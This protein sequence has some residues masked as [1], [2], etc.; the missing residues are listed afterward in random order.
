MQ[1]K[2]SAGGK[3]QWL[4]TLYYVSARRKVVV[5]PDSELRDARP[6]V[7][8]KALA[9]LVLKNLD[10]EKLYQP[11]LEY[12]AGIFAIMKLHPTVMD[13]KCQ[14]DARRMAAAKKP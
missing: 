3:S 5:I 8:T 11:R 12:L 7:R 10:A 13:R 14:K 4:E 9:E 2:W 6:R 1:H